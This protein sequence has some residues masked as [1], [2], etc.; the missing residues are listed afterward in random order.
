MIDAAGQIHVSARREARIVSLVPSLTQLLFDLDLGTQMVGRTRFCVC[1]DAAAGLPS[2]GGPKTPD[3]DKLLALRPSHVVVNIDE[4]PKAVAD[5]LRTAGVTVIVTHP[6][7]PMDNV[8]LYRL[9]GHIFDRPDRAG[10]LEARFLAA[11]RRLT[12]AAEQWP[13]RRVLYLIWRKP[14]M[15]VGDDTYVGRTLA[16]A[17]LRVAPIAGDDRRY[18]VVAIDEALL[19]RVDLVLFPSEP[20]VFQERHLDDFR[21]RYG[22]PDLPLLTIDGRTAAWYGSH[23]IQGLEDLRAFVDRIG[24][25][26]PEPAS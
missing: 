24:E 8:G 17:G 7:G 12:R 6:T 26:A 14:W 20:F 13:D 18:P 23:A 25:S 19:D 16:A 10:D 3:I 21:R 15:T 1:P 11:H 4:N 5:R 9:L 22:H 2:L